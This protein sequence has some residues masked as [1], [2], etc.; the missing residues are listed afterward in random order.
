M[1]VLYRKWI[2]IG[3]GQDKIID[4][5]KIDTQRLGSLETNNVPQA[6]LTERS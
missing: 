1:T 5:K 2:F 6:V 3:K 4:K